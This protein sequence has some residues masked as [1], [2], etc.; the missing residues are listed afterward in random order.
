MAKYITLIGNADGKSNSV[1]LNLPVANGVTVT[2]GDFV[3]FTGGRVSSATITGDVRLVG[4][5]QSTVTGNSAGTNKVLVVV[6]PEAKYLIGAS[7]ALAAT[8]VGQYFDLTGATGVQQVLTS[9]AS[10]TT[11]VLI[12]LEFNPQIDPVKT[13]TTYGIFKI[14]EHAFSPLGA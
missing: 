11:G 7:T 4:Q 1:T 13:D 8:N 14:V 6:D 9:S 10:N 5:A 2:Q 12:C 3:Y